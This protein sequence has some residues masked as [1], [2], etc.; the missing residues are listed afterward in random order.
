MIIF[1]ELPGIGP[2]TALELIKEYGDIEGLIKNADKIKQEKRK[3]IIKDSAD[4]IRVSLK[5]VSLDKKINLPLILMKLN[6]LLK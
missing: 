5:L 2:K 3:N 4:D 1:Q 6:L